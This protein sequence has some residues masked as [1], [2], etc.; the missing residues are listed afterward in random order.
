MHRA[1]VKSHRPAG[2]ARI[3][4]QRCFEFRIH[5]G[6]GHN[7]RAIGR[8]AAVHR[9]DLCMNLRSGQMPFFNKQFAQGN[10][11]RLPIAQVGVVISAI[12]MARGGQAFMAVVMLVVVVIMGH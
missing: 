2:R 3:G 9:V 12:G 4:E 10:L 11:H 8:A 1:N 5:P 7:A 6:P